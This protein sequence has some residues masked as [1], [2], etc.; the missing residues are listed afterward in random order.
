M[1]ISIDWITILVAF[2]VLLYSAA[3]IC[4][5]RAYAANTL[6]K[7][8]KCM[9]SVLWLFAP[10]WIPFWLLHRVLLVGIKR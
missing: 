9:V 8:T 6:D 5:R 4:L 7:D 2:G 10:V 1:Q 3:A